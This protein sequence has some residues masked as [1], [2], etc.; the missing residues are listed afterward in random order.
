M[1]LPTDFAAIRNSV[2]ILELAERLNIPVERNRARCFH[3]ERHSHGDRTPSMSFN[4]KKNTFRCFVCP[5]VGGSVIDLVMHAL[6]TDFRGAVAWL[7][8][9]ELPKQIKTH[10]IQTNSL[11]YND[12]NN[13]KIYKV[14][15]DLCGQVSD[16]ALKYLR[17][18]RIF[19]KTVLAAGIKSINDYPAISDALRSSFTLD[20]L[21]TAGLF[22]D[23]AHFR[24]YKHRI[25]IPYLK[26]GEV[27]YFQARAMDKETTP[28]ELNPSGPFPFPYNV[29]SIA[30]EKL[31]YLCEGAI[32][33]L[34]LMENAFPAAGIPGAMNFK[35]EWLPFFKGKRV[36]SVL[37]NDR[38]GRQGNE[39]LQKLFSAADIPFSV[40]PI[41]EGKD[42]N[43]IFN[44]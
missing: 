30:K 11:K 23:R 8:N 7:K 35:H 4:P 43:A 34:T 2:P 32:D 15:F 38:A 22:N 14:L 33:T 13:G 12:N 18:R 37:D 21:K 3:P 17:G 29:H 16:E 39:R 24:F 42:I 20:E 25:L 19:R 5:D 36:F 6:K 10:F 44:R 1:T 28:K 31:V 26:D 41:P 9:E 27:R 40:I